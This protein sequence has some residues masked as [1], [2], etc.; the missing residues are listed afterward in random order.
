MKKIPIEAHLKGKD[1]KEKLQQALHH[2]TKKEVKM[3]IEDEKEHTPS[4][5]VAGAIALAHLIKE[6]KY[7]ER[8]KQAHIESVDVFEFNFHDILESSEDEPIGGP[9]ASSEKDIRDIAAEKPKPK[10][11]LAARATHLPTKALSEPVPTSRTVKAKP[12]VPSDLFG[13]EKEYYQQQTAHALKHKDRFA[14]G[15]PA[16]F[17]PQPGGKPRTGN[18]VA[19]GVQLRTSGERTSGE[20]GGHP[21]QTPSLPDHS[22]A[23][24][25]DQAIA[26]KVTLRTLS[27]KMKANWKKQETD[28]K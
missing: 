20:G 8:M 24:Y 22:P 21:V 1:A 28:A 14:K 2:F 25:S 4:P 23:K 3:G 11:G 26:N 5:V 13:S 16:L 19:K 7:Y 17:L 27:T 9:T 6:P 18:V 10:T 15:V 12:S